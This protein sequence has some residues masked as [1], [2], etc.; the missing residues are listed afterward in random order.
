MLVV[1]CVIPLVITIWVMIPTPVVANGMNFRIEWESTSIAIGENGTV[2]NGCR[3]RQG[4]IPRMIRTRPSKQRIKH[5]DSV[6]SA[7]CQVDVETT[8]KDCDL[9]HVSFDPVGSPIC[10]S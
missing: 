1:V 2:N 5:D 3:R 10:Q 4:E 7:M 9:F 8:I 6:L